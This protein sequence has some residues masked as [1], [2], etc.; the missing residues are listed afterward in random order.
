MSDIKKR[1]AI[2]PW[3]EF[4]CAYI[5]ISPR[6]KR[7][8]AVGEYF[9][10]EHMEH[11]NTYDNY[12]VHCH[13]FMTFGCQVGSVA[14]EWDAEL[15]PIQLSFECNK[16]FKSKEDNFYEQATEHWLFDYAIWKGHWTQIAVDDER[17]KEAFLDSDFAHIF[18]VLKKYATRDNPYMPD[19]KAA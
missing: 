13:P 2:V 17:L 11:Q 12:D 19:E 8:H 15:G 14:A 1:V 4:P 6:R 18:N 3:P 10:K 9:Y 5:A 16:D 7:Q